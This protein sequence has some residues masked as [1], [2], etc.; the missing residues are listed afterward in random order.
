MT[1]L[2]EHSTCV[3]DISS[4]EETEARRRDERGKENVPPLDDISQTQSRLPSASTS[5]D[6]GFVEGKAKAKR[7]MRCRKEIEQGAIE[8]DREP[9]RDLVAEE[10]YPEGCGEG[11]VV[12][13]ADEEHED[14]TPAL[15]LSS[16][17][18]LSPTSP[19]LSL[20]TPLS[21]DLTACEFDFTVNM[22]SSDMDVKGKGRMVE[23][24]ELMEKSNSEM[25]AQAAV[26]AP[27]EKAEEGFEVWESGSAKGDD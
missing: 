27:I 23:I 3:L 14:E 10:F 19:A 12:F 22:S 6:G 26:F 5:L 17:H 9:L 15:L 16:T 24:D 18:T 11:D 25:P 2:M 13:V 1:N 20:P 4:D 21:A 7:S 8:I